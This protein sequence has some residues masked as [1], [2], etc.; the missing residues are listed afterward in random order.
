MASNWDISIR[1]SGTPIARKSWI[2]YLS[3]IVI[4]TFFTAVAAPFIGSFSPAAGLIVG[5]IAAGTTLWRIF[6][7]RSVTLM[8]DDVGVWL[9]SGVL[10][11]D[12]GVT[13]VKWRDLDEAEFR[14]SVTGWL[15]RSHT[16]RI[17]HRY[18]KASEIVLTDM[19]R[20]EVAVALI[21]QLHQD[22]VRRNALA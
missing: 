10:P 22:M 19:S 8:Y 5:G 21:N 7:L 17:G 2:A 9:F 14:Q 12:A 16:I 1:A 13:G 15:F 4:G 6:D 11:W 18:T 20:G 3:V